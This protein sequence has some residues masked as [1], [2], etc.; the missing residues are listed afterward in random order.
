MEK[1]CVLKGGISGEREIS[2]KS[3]EFVERGLKGAGYEVF[4][5][6]TRERDFLPQ[7][8]K[9]SPDVVFIALHGPYGE[10]GTVQGLLEMI[11]IPYTGS[12]V[13]A[14]ALA[15]NKIYSKAIFASQGLLI[16]SFQTVKRDEEINPKI[17]PPLIVKPPELGSTLG[18]SLVKNAGYLREALNIAFQY[19]SSCAILEEY[20]MGKEITVG[21]IDDPQP[22]ALPIIEI[23]PK[24]VLYDYK[25]KYVK[26]F[27]EYNVPAPLKKRVYLKAEEV[28]L[29]A[30]QSLGCRDF[31]RVDMIVREDDVFLFEVNSIPGMTEGSLLPRAARAA[32]LTFS[33]LVD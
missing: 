24:R 25:A 23:L 20:I 19:N 11:G 17:S 30:Y 27:C 3:G 31:A 33:Q 6:D 10:D 18:V 22:C 29:R 12:G 16:P 32:G 14:S 8:I 21:I 4:S 26:G 2:L 1:V 7:L 13:L 15:M 5:I 9:E 28:A